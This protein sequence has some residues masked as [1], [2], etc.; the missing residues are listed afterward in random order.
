M[1]R[2]TITAAMWLVIYYLWGINAL[3]VCL[4]GWDKLVARRRSRRVPERWLL[5]LSLLG[6][7]PGALLSRWIFR[8]KRRKQPFVRWLWAIAAAQAAVLVLAAEYV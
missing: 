1:P 4:M 3:T 8:H 6:G 5:R 7:S 2:A